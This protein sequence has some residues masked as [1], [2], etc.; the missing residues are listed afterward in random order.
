MDKVLIQEQLLDYFKNAGLCNVADTQEFELMLLYL[1]NFVWLIASLNYDAK[2]EIEKL[3]EQAWDDYGKELKSRP[4]QEVGA[5][6]SESQEQDMKFMSD[7]RLN[8]KNFIME[9]LSN[10]VYNFDV[11]R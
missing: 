1:D 5:T 9:N 8:F 2:Q 11:F 4:T 3:V 10:I 6:Q 7:L